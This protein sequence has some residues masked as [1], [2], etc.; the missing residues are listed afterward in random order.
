M[1]EKVMKRVTSKKGVAFFYNGS[2]VKGLKKRFMARQA[3]KG[4]SALLRTT[5]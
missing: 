3:L 4:P 2:W 5:V 1:K